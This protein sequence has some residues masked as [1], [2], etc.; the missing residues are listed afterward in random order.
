MFGVL[1]I[2]RPVGEARSKTTMPTVVVWDAETDC[3]FAMLAGMPR[4]QQMRT[5]QATVVCAMVFDSEESIKPGNWDAA[6]E[7]ATKH[8]FWRDKADEGKK[9]FDG[10]LQLFDEAELLVAFNGLGFDLP[11]MR[12]YYG[13][14]NAA[15][16][17]YLEHRLKTHDPMIRVASAADMPYPKLD[18]LLQ[19][20]HLPQKL[21]SGLHAI[22]MWE[23]GQRESLQE[24]C[25]TDVLFLAQLVHLNRVVVPGVGALPNSVLGVASAIKCQRILQPLSVDEEFVVV[26]TGEAMVVAS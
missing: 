26:E 11:V 16:Q 2:L 13:S 7:T 3:S 1:K 20:N 19:W 15:R 23:E 17:R 4:E 25:M 8:T 5:M 10:L 21:T 24:Y 18:K 22:R 12:K 14:T 6:C 9:P